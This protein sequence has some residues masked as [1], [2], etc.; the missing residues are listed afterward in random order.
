[1]TVNYADLCAYI[2]AHE[3]TVIAISSYVLEG[4]GIVPEEATAE[5]FAQAVLDAQDD[6]IEEYLTELDFLPSCQ[7]HPA[8]VT[9]QRLGTPCRKM[10]GYLW[11]G[12]MSLLFY[13]LCQTRIV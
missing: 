6:L 5:E 9:G 1:M 11:Q 2:A 7:R 13:F 4:W 12:L 3:D 8:I 10:R